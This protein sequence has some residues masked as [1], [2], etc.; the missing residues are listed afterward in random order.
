M[1]STHM[2]AHAQLIKE[3][4]E[5]QGNDTRTDAETFQLRHALLNSVPFWN[6]RT[7]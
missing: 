6:V 2:Q 3:R 7:S 1:L 5:Y 4:F